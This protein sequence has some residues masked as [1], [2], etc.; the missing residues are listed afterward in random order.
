MSTL[1]VRFHD[2]SLDSLSWFVEQSDGANH[3]VNWQTGSQKDLGNLAKGH[4]TVVLAIAQ[5]D[6]YLTSY[7]IPSK[8][9]R[10]VLSEES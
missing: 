8:A 9:A 5:Q 3:P 10:Q 4:S 7:E 1:I 6:I 2:S